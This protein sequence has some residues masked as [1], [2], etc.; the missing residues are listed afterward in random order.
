MVI[1]FSILLILHSLTRW[2]LLLVLLFAIYR[3]AKGYFSRSATFSP[4]DNSL[5]HGTATIAHIQLVLG[6]LLYVKSPLVKSFWADAKAALPYME[7]TFFSVIHFALMLL[8]ITIITI[9]SALAKRK[10][11]P[12]EQYKTMFVWFTIALLI[13]FIAIPWPFSPLA[14]RPLI[15]N[16]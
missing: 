11:L 4:I 2:L 8:A 12:L 1:M 10:Q 9:G 15:Q 13:I 14:S 3:A 16:F 5:R 6:I 7:L